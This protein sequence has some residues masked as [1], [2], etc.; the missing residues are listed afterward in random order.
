[1]KNKIAAFIVSFAFVFSL[2]G[3][4]SSESNTPTPVASASV[5]NSEVFLIVL[6]ENTDSWDLVSD[7]QIVDLATSLCGAWSRGASFED[8][9]S[10]MLNSGYSAGEGGYFIGAATEVYCPE[11][12][13]IIEDYNS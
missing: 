8:V 11:F 2:A 1:M 10:V 12:G 4:S 5:S 3:C 7:A 13:S 9:A 6:H